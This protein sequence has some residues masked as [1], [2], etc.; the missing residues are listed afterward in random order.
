MKRHIVGNCVM[1]RYS[2]IIGWSYELGGSY[3]SLL[4]TKTNVFTVD[5]QCILFS[6]GIYFL[7]PVGQ[8]CCFSVR[9]EAV[10]PFNTND[11][12]QVRWRLLSF[13]I[14]FVY[15]TYFRCGIRNTFQWKITFLLMEWHLVKIP[16]IKICIT[17]FLSI[18]EL[19]PLFRFFF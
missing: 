8:Q 16:A 15:F 9:L 2:N 14:L 13:S 19:N 17:A 12:F 4:C 18:T 6:N 3:T 7:A 5:Y 1:C 10:G 11:A